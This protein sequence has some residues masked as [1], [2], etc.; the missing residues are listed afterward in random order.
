MQKKRIVTT[1]LISAVFSLALGAPLMAQTTNFKIDDL[2]LSSKA[3]QVALERRIEIAIKQVCRS[4][5]VT[6]SI[7]QNTRGLDECRT[8]ARRQIDAQIASMVRNERLTR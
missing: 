4:R 1:A 8:E 2:D 6:G 7:I 3:G 5:D